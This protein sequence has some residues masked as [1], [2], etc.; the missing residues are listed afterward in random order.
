MLNYFWTKGWTVKP[1]CLWRCW[2]GSAALFKS[3]KRF[4]A[5]FFFPMKGVRVLHWRKA[6]STSRWLKSPKYQLGLKIPVNV[7]GGKIL[8][9]FGLSWVTFFPYNA[10]STI[11]I[12]RANSIFSPRRF[13]SRT[14]TICNVLFQLIVNCF[15][16][17]EQITGY[18]PGPATQFASLSSHLFSK[19]RA[20]GRPSAS[21]FKPVCFCWYLMSSASCTS[22]IKDW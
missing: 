18:K 5:F 17:S 7:L 11:Q 21:H 22:S 6:N 19:T 15:Q 14:V 12:S 8:W 20:L 1:R 13:F 10:F 16:I 2:W 9:K 4:I 3:Q